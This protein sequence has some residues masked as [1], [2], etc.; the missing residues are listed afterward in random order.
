[1]KKSL[2]AAG[3]LLGALSSSAM[4][5][6]LNGNRVYEVTITNLTKGMYFTPFFVATHK[7]S[8][9]IR[10][11]R[12]GDIASEELESV[13]EGGDISGYQNLWGNHPRVH[14]NQSTQG[15]IAPGDTKTLRI[16]SKGRYQRMSLVAMMLPTNDTVAVAQNVRFPKYGKKAFML[17]AL[18]AGTETNSE[19]CHD[20]PG[21]CSD[22]EGGVG[23][24]PDDK[25]EGFVHTSPG[26]HGEAN[27]TRKDYDWRGAVGRVTVKFI[28]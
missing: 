5:V 2:I 10:V 16:E 1:M 8:P 21:K 6:E 9:D 27:L 28:H 14:D 19:L 12:R 15:L 18:D 23:L 4:A 7:K 24:S 26:V 25:G 13:A 3:M 11:L 17:R 20:I 22:Y